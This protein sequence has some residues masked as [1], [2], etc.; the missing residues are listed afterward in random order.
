MTAASVTPE[1]T[2]AASAAGETSLRERKKSAT[3]QA[4]EDAA[5]ALFAERGYEATSVNDIAAR[6]DVAPRTFFR[7]FPTKEAVLYG[8]LDDALE[9]FA[10]TFRGRPTDEPVLESLTASVETMAAAFQKDRK[11]MIQRFEIQHRATTGAEPGEYARER[12]Q[13]LV[14]ELVMEREQ[15]QPDCELRAR[16]VTGLLTMVQSVAN[17]HW[18][19]HGGD[20]DLHEVGTHCVA[21]LSKMLLGDQ[22]S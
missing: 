18:L 22:R 14:Y 16:L 19:A 2:D 8:D 20:D 11:R 9:R 6:A 3:R 13:A 21:L 5:W 15:G 17:D 12:F 10:D 4:I 7:Y 1:T